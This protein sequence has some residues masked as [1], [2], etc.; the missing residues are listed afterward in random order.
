MG[1]LGYIWGYNRR[2]GNAEGNA[3]WVLL[4]NGNWKIPSGG[5]G[6]GFPTEWEVDESTEAVVGQVNGPGYLM[7]TA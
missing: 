7:K 5:S 6:L 4:R 3:E 2:Q 1:A